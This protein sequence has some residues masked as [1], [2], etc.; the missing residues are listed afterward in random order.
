M[1]KDSS[2][3]PALDAYEA[4]L[5]RLS[6]QASIRLLEYGPFKAK[7]GPLM[8]AEDGSPDAALVGNHEQALLREFMSL[9]D[10]AVADYKKMGQ[11]Y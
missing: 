10:K 3:G 8:V 7:I 5:R 9:L 2:W 6:P 4:L 11:A 1:E